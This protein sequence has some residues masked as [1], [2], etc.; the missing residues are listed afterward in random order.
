[1]HEENEE[2]EAELV[3]ASVHRGVVGDGGS[4]RMKPWCCEVET[5]SGFDSWGR[6]K[7]GRSRWVRMRTRS[8]C[9]VQR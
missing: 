4:A 9:L 1:L 3:V 2:R 7:K 8:C 6:G 5:L